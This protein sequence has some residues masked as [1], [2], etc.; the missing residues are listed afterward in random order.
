MPMRNPATFARS[1]KKR[2]R[3]ECG[4]ERPRTAAFRMPCHWLTLWIRAC[5]NVSFEIRASDWWYPESFGVTM[6]SLEPLSLRGIHSGRIIKIE[7][8]PCR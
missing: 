8:I 2:W 3:R 1:Y 5:A 6:A 4:I 7:G